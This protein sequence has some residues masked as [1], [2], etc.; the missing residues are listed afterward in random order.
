MIS[1][2]F[3]QSPIVNVGTV[4]IHLYV[5]SIFSLSDILNFALVALNYIDD[6]LGLTV[7]SGFNCKSSTRCLSGEFVNSSYVLACFTRLATLTVTLIRYKCGGLNL[8]L[9]I[10]FF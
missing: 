4:A 9:T 6:V 5:E 2:Q 8:A 1:Y 7:S 3:F 10:T